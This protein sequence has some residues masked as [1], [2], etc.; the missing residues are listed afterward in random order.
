MNLEKQLAIKSQRHELYMLTL[1]KFLQDTF[2]CQI[3]YPWI[4]KNIKGYAKSSFEFLH[5]M[6]FLFCSILFMILIT[7][8]YMYV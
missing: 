7:D 8:L 4:L 1:Q 6:V 3:I 2:L 5:D